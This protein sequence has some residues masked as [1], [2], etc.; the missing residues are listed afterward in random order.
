MAGRKLK[1]KSESEIHLFEKAKNPEP[2]NDMQREKE[3]KKEKEKEKE[4]EEKEE[5][6]KEKEEEKEAEKPKVKEPSKPLPVSASLTAM[7]TLTTYRDFLEN[8][9]FKSFRRNLNLGPIHL[10]FEPVLFKRWR[11]VDVATT[12]TFLMAQIFQ[13]VTPLEFMDGAWSV[14]VFCFVFVFFFLFGV[15]GNGIYFSFFLLFVFLTKES[16]LH[17]LQKNKN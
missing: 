14:C 10:I 13:D 2:E 5:K 4:K 15:L 16:H 6:K 11:V 3:E 12:V 17:F 7:T 8:D 9:T 1:T